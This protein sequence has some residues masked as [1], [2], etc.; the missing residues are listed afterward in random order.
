MIGSSLFKMTLRTVF[1]LLLTVLL[2]SSLMAQPGT[3]K[4]SFQTGGAVQGTPAIGPEGVIYVGAQDKNLYAINPDG[5][6]KWKFT[7]DQAFLEPPAIGEDDTIYAAANDGTLY[8]LNPDGSL[9]WTFVPAVANPPSEMALAEDGTIYYAVSQT[10]YAVHPNGSQFWTITRGAESLV[11]G[12]SIGQD[13]V[14]LA[15]T[16]GRLIALDPLTGAELWVFIGGGGSSDMG[17]AVAEDGTIYFG[18][19]AA[20]G[21]NFFAVNPNGSLKWKVALDAQ[22]TAGPSLVHCPESSCS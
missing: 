9:K 1:I 8:A 3:Q 14:V 19:R 2:G 11:T 10:Y 5:T 22:I 6:E 12:I 21:D 17:P 18:Q 20:V 13:G 7:A 15:T 16:Q 4:W